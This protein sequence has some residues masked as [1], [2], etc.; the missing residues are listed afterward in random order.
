MSDLDVLAPAPASAPR[1]TFPLAAPA[2]YEPLRVLGSGGAGTVVLARD[3]SLGR[4]VAL[5]F[6][7]AKAPEL[8]ER[9][10]REARRMARLQHPSIVAVHEFDVHA[11]RAYL[12][13]D[14]VDGGNLA[15]A[16]FEPR[17]LV[18]VLRPIVSALEHAHE[19]GI[20]HRDIKPE[21]VLL[22]R[23]ARAYLCDFGLALDPE[24]DGLAPLVAGT[25]LSMSPEQTRG[26]TPR[27]ASDVFSLGV[28]LYRQL[29]HEW[30][31][32]GRTLADLLHAIR[33]A[34]PRPPRA[35]EPAIPRA[36][37]TIVLR[38]LAKETAQR[39]GSMGELGRALDRFLERR[40]F[41]A[42]LRGP[43]P[44]PRQRSTFETPR[45]HPEDDS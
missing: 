42:F 38:C 7:N 9:F 23:R 12:A 44:S 43:R 10:R 20:V 3:R 30:P 1:R 6:L 14:Y 18:R 13:L 24:D 40:S 35:L 32:R 2:K 39:F 33:H 11:G 21:N 27:A 22:D 37:E 28:T 31:F 17:E 41:L 29:T 36:L 8:F 4:L 26:E 25:P 5:K 19:L 16:R 15:G 45:I 34:T